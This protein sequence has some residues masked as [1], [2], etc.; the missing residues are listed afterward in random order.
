[1]V[2]DDAS[3]RRVM[4]AQLESFQYRTA[5]AADAA[6]ALEILETEPKELVLAELKLP[7][8]SGLELLKR[9]RADFPE[10]SVVIVTAF[11]SIET[12]VEAMKCGA[13]DYLTKP[14][15]PDELRAVVSHVMER[16]RQIEETQTLRNSLD[17]MFGFEDIIGRSDELLRVL[18]SATR[19]AQSDATVLIL[20]E[21][22]TGKELL[23]KAIHYNSARKSAPFV[24]INCGSIPRELIESE[25][26]GH[27]KGSFT[28]ALTHRKGKVEVADGGTILLDEIGELLP[29]LQPRVLRLIQEHEIETVGSTTPQKVDVRI[30]A[31][32]HRDLRDL[33]AEGKF[34]EDLYYRLA[35]I[36][37]EL[38]PL[39]H[40]PGDI[41]ILVYEFFERFKRAH[42]RPELRFPP[43][44]L[45]YFENYLWPGNVRELANALERIVLLCRSNEVSLADLPDTLRQG[46]ADSQTPKPLETEIGI[47]LEAVERDL[48][49]SAL[50][51]HNWNQSRAARHLSISRKT[52]LYRMAK[53]GISRD[54]G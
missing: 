33:V 35:V 50:R 44:L 30:V 8:M 4:Q 11:G 6:E 10:T 40:R 12:A 22:G 54:S 9:V 27:I 37:I 52:L 20:G 25:L 28:G 32:T 46:L 23:A 24:V 45:P 26:F 3:L 48:I 29:D 42:A 2:E 31:A 5:V 36:P 14:V 1:V 17:Q 43:L 13:H 38:P 53:H 51:L 16:H 49:L 15:H 7:G 18:N 39:R 19:I 34:R 41:P 47:S 21:T